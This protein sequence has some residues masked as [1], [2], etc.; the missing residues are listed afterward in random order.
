MAKVYIIYFDVNVGDLISG[1]NHGIASIIGSLKKNGN[2]VILS[3]VRTEIELLQAKKDVEREKPD[4]IGLSFSTNQKKYV[5]KFLNIL[6]SRAKSSVIVGGGIHVTVSREEVFKEIPKL[7]AICIGEGEKPLNDLC[8]RI[9]KKT[10]YFSV[11]SFYFKLH[12]RIIKNPISPLQ[13][14]DKLAFPD[15][16]YYDYKRIISENG[17]WF[18]MMVS[19]GCP[20]NCSYCSNQSVKEI[21]PNK[22]KYVRFPTIKYAINMIKNN[23]QLIPNANKIAFDDDILTLDRKWL[24]E[25]CIEYKKEIDLP[26][27]CNVRV[28][29]VNT[30]SI[31]YLKDAGCQVINIGVESGNEWLRRHILNRFHSNKMIKRA[32]KIINKFNIRNFSFNMV[33]LPFE[34]NAMA[35]DTYLLNNELRPSSGMLSYFYPYPGTT[36]YTLC[37][38]YELFHDDLE[39]VSSLNEAPSV[40]EI[41][42]THKEIKNNYEKMKIYFYMRLVSSRIHLPYFFEKVVLKILILFK[43]PILYLLNPKLKKSKKMILRKTLRSFAM[44]YLR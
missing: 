14:I 28:E 31:K 11:N 30:N 10:N 36:I 40:K 12:N 29:T 4:V 38:K 35:T 27:L 9:D 37:R 24:K 7:N 2:E 5:I 21:Y 33:G 22:S 39:S 19:R 32:F 23:L 13:Q 15:Y 18:R 1:Y 26:F 34:T 3:H 17:G 25:F 20:Y 8:S 41:F 16:S 43:K 6:S 42:M 44:R